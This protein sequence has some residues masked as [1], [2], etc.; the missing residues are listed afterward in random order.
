VKKYILI[1]VILLSGCGDKVATRYENEC[2][3]A[4]KGLRDFIIECARVANPM[5]D[6]EGEDLVQ[7]CEYT[8]KS[9]MCPKIT[10]SV[11]YSWDMTEK[12]RIQVQ[13]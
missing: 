10:Y 6:E 8:G 5:S 4:D 1:M 7:Q 13:K 12:R 2:L 9:I 11:I 3:P